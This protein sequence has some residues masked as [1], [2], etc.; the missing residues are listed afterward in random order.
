MHPRFRHSTSG[1]YIRSSYF[2]QLKSLI[3]QN[4]NHCD[5]I[6]SLLHCYNDWLV[7]IERN[8]L[9]LADTLH[10]FEKL[11]QILFPGSPLSRWISHSNVCTR[12]TFNNIFKLTNA[13]TITLLLQL[14]ERANPLSMR[15]SAYPGICILNSTVL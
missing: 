1:K 9:V 10:R 8:V 15:H 13:I 2:S 6:T 14:L 4:L 5:S 11:P 12:K 7:R 3:F